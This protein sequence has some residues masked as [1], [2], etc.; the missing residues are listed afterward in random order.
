MSKDRKSAQYRKQSEMIQQ[1]PYN[2]DSRS[3]DEYTMK[4]P[5]IS[6]TKDNISQMT[7]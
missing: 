2:M 1:M 3:R 4:T 5:K 6:K 7:H